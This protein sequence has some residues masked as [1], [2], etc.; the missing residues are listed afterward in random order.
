MKEIRFHKTNLAKHNVL[1]QEAEEAV[2]DGWSRRRR[3]GKNFEV[4]GRTSAG[5]YLQLVCDVAG[6][7]VRVF[8]ARDMTETERRRYGK[9]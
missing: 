7:M 2:L 1:P 6:D 9:K 3:D 4:F 8:H 5:R